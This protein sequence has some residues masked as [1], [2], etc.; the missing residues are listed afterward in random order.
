MATA[1]RSAFGTLLKI[2]DGATTETFTTI[3]EI[4]DI[5]G[6]FSLDTEE[7]TSHSST[8]GWVERIATLLD[9]GKL[10]IKANWVS[11]HA[12]Q[13]YSTGVLKDKVNRTLRNFQLVIPAASTTTW[14][15][16][17]YVTGFKFELPVKG[18]QELE[19]ELTISGKPTLA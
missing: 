19:L 17:A 8:D 4:K 2:G 18:A 9:G 11:G 1:A 14:T 3:A 6:D 16:P 13:S 12:T 10:K 5:K 7:V 15:I